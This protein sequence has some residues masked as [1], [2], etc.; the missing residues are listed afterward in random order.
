[1]T[2]FAVPLA[3]FATLAAFLGVGL[4][5]DPSRIPSPLVGKAA[6]DF[7]LPQLRE[8]QQVFSPR[9][10][11]GQVWILNVWASWCGG[12]RDEHPLLMAL[13][14]SAA[15]PVYGIDYKDRRED[16][17]AWLARWGDPYEVTGMDASGRVGIEYGVYGVPETYLIDKT[18]VIRYKQI[19]PLDEETLHG[20]LL[21]LIRELQNR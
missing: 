20:T 5:L 17:L 12:C 21:P 6:P 4:T 8:P 2:R 11:A 13:A 14:K 18:G 10:G 7:S 16:A 15:V 3:V 1:M 19:G 9:D